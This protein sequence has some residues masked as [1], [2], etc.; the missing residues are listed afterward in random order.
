[1]T[2]PIRLT[3]LALSHFLA[4]GVPGSIVHISS[5]AA[6]FPT[7]VD[8]IYAV[9]KA[10]VSAL[11]RSFAILE[12]QMNVRVTGVAPGVVKTPLFVEHKNKSKYVDTSKDLWVT[13]DEVAE[14]MIRLVE[15]EELIGGT[16][17][18]V[19]ADSTR[20]VTVLNDPGTNLK[21]PGFTVSGIYEALE[22]N[23]ALARTPG[24]GEVP[25]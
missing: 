2:H 9:S 20:P 16:V 17:L 15:E 4:R 21:G 13:P 1:M 24:W 23:L 7:P 5:V 11:I 3:Q 18:E 25:K 8:P 22:A 19:G 12:S 6:Q 10:G 14:A